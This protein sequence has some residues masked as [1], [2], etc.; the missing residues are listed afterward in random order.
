MNIKVLFTLMSIFAFAGLAVGQGSC[1]TVQVSSPSD[2]TTSAPVA[3]SVNVS[4]GDPSV[5]PTYNWTVSAGMIESGQG[6]SV[7]VVETT[8]L[9]GQSITATVDVGGFD[10]A[11]STSQSSTTSIQSNIVARLIDSF[12]KIRVKDERARLDNF[13]IELQNDPVAQGYVI[14]YAGRY[15]KKGEAAL[16]M[17]R[18]STHL[19]R[20]RK[21]AKTRIITVDGGHRDDMTIDLWLVP[22]GAAPP[23][24]SPTVPPAEVARTGKR[25]G[26][27][28]YPDAQLLSDADA[29]YAKNDF[30]GA[31]AKYTKAIAV[32][33]KNA[34]SYQNRGRARYGKGD[35]DGAIADYTRNIAM[36]PKAPEPY[37]YRGL[38][39]HSKKNYDK[40]IADY[41]K[42][43]Q[44]MPTHAPSLENRG[45][46][47]RNK[48]DD[49]GALADFEKVISLDPASDTALFHR[50]NIRYDAKELDKAIADYDTVIRLNPRNKFAY[51]YRGNARH[52]KVE[53]DAAI[54]DFTKAIEID[55]AFAEGY[56]DRAISKAL[57]GDL[58]GSLLDLTKAI[59][60]EPRN[61]LF[62]RNRAR[63]YRRLGKTDQSIADDE[64]AAELEQK[65]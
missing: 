28:L 60:L 12:G 21:L 61:P 56:G 38:A 25:R 35:Y 29:L 54:A 24:A 59:A 47:R 10:R 18:V 1:P 14:V 8:G 45:I 43:L 11:C 5:T 22:S 30:D 23:T 20:T 9:A 3:F 48:R 33:P 2:G 37:Y 26:A 13:A 41:T 63:T 31:I 53:Y 32:N 39:Y 7:I 51:F 49:L 16:V 17:K 19:V 52:Q 65:K 64:K 62:Y 57:K 6:T 36:T 34:L 40:A 55:P 4:G 42:V 46:A 27:S 44:I 58:D 50:A 15:A